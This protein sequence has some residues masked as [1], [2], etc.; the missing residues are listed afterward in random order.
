MFDH[1]DNDNEKKLSC[2]SQDFTFIRYNYLDSS[3]ISVSKNIA[4]IT[5]TTL[6]WKLFF[7]LFLMVI[8]YAQ[9]TSTANSGGPF[10]NSSSNKKIKIP[11]HS[12]ELT[13][14]INIQRQEYL[15]KQ[16]AVL[17]YQNTDLTN[18]TENQ[19]KHMIIDRQHRLLY[20]YVPKVSIIS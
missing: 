5:T 6:K 3:G 1:D 15:Q 16:C 13:Q 4:L 12:L 8:L 18:L 17:G 9:P 2:V 14:S 19:M 11:K 7:F 20:C 10:E